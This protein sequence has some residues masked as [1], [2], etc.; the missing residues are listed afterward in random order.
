MSARTISRHFFWLAILGL[1]LSFVVACGSPETSASEETDNS[2]QTEENLIEEADSPTQEKKNLSEE[3]DRSNQ[4]KEGFIEKL[5]ETFT[6]AEETVPAGTELEVRLDHAIGTASNH[7]GDEFTARLAS[8]LVMNGKLLAPAGSAVTGVLPTVDDSNRVKGRAVMS[9][10]LKSIMVDG[11]HYSLETHPLTIE[12]QDTKK[13]DAAVIAGSAAAGTVIGAITGGKKGAAI[14][15]GLGGGAG[16]GYV[17]A[18]KGKEVEFGPEARLAFTLSEA[19]T[20]PVL[21]ESR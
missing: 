3:A 7:P 16:T 4:T 12:A 10:A 8:D 18:T 1:L 14:G 2:N 13:K 11:E 20:L 21:D 17:L 15:A 5:T 19:V 9:L 6:Q